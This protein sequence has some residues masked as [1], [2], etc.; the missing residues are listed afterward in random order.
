[1]ATEALSLRRRAACAVL[2]PVLDEDALLDALRLQ[3]QSMR[4]DGVADIIR[5][6]DQVA[7]R[8]AIDPAA[9]KKLYEAFYKALRLPE[10]QLPMDPWPLMHP[11]AAAPAPAVATPA[12]PA[13]A[14]P[15]A[16]PTINPVA[17]ALEAAAP[18]VAPPT[19][20]AARPNAAPATPV[21]PAASPLPAEQAVC[22]EL[23]RSALAEVQRFHPGALKDLGDSA[24]DL[25]ETMRLAPSLRRTLRELW[26]RPLQSHWVLD[27][28]AA[29]LSQVVH[30][31][32]MALCEALG[33]VEADQVLT[34]AVRA[35]DQSPQA[36]QFSP[37][38]LI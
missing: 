14:A 3:H 27:L 35:A 36:R 28:P 13:P 21:A 23:V 10:D 24:L 25:L 5:Y 34:R 30:L 15:A 9:R 2:S 7:E 18:P 4:G 20:P 1:M 17:A 8:H 12:A 31:L 6:I 29:D 16:R 38:R 32:Y 19:L 11:P 33:P 22:A 26:A 37:R